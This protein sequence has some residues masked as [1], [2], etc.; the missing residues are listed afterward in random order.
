MLTNYF[1]TAI[2]FL[3]KDRLYALINLTGSI[4]GLAAIILIIS[5]VRYEFSYDRNYSNYKRVYRVILTNNNQGVSTASINVP[6][7]VSNILT[8]ELPQ[9]E[10]VT[11]LDDDGSSSFIKGNA[12]ID[13]SVAQSDSNFFKVFNLPFVYG[14]PKTALNERNNIVIDEET[15]KKFF[16]NKNPVGSTLTY[17]NVFGES[18]P[19]LV[20]GVMKNLPS[21]V[22]FKANAISAVNFKQ[23]NLS[24]ASMMITSPQYVLLKENTS[25]EQLKPLLE[26]IYR[27]Y[28]FPT[29]TTL[30]FQ[31]VKNIHLYSNIQD[32]QYAQGNIKYIYI[33]A[34]AAFLILLIACVNYINLTTARSLQRAKEIG[35]RK[36]LGAKKIQVI[37]QFLTES[38][39]F[40]FIALPLAFFLAFFLWPSLVRLLNIHVDVDFLLTW[41]NIIYLLLIGTAVGL[42]SGL[43]PALTT[44]LSRPAVV[45][46]G[47]RFINGLRIDIRKGLIVFQFALSIILIISAILINKQLRLLNNMQLG[48]EKDHL[49]VVETGRFP[50]GSSVFK[51]ELSR[52]S[53]VKNV[54]ISG[55]MLGK[56]YSMPGTDEKKED[57][58]TGSDTARINKPFNAVQLHADFDFIKTMQLKLVSGRGFSKEYPSDMLNR[59]SILYGKSNLSENQKE[60]LLNST[61]IILSEKAVSALQLKNPIGK[62]VSNNLVRGTVIGVIKDFEGTNLKDNMPPVVLYG[63]ADN[64]FGN[65]YIRIA[66]GNLQ[67]TINYID[68]TVKKVLPYQR[69]KLSFADD[70]LQSLYTSEKRLASLFNIFSGL[71]ILITI[72]GLFSLIALLTQQRTKEIGI[73]KVLGANTYSII[74]LFATDLIKLIIISVAI[75]SPI[76]WLFLNKWLQGYAHRTN[77]SWWIFLVAGLSTIVIALIVISFQAIK[78][79]LANPVAALRSE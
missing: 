69:Y 13:V 14:N 52:N 50:H 27:K 39:L 73:R 47:E 62:V 63:E 18:R 3:Y 11:T 68:E 70:R 12:L 44:S 49:L 7:A 9:V 56:N 29:G 10:M 74:N 4:I 41:Q 76:A 38:L 6:L 64:N 35:M 45:L 16:Q 61:P 72:L 19:F 57:Q 60:A 71:A 5:Y 48:F 17:K 67:N 40:F 66:P 20:T 24:W 59:D 46:K 37:S 22:H 78:A 55:W 36:V 77:I 34:S 15:A 30:T 58:N 32:D 51:N 33:F 26:N 43:Y 28:N 31:D 1:K 42:L 54:S 65:T 21:N 75:A 53:Y 79:A 23:Q 25:V 2:R 8:R